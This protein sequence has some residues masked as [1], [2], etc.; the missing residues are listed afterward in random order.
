VA[1]LFSLPT[2]AEWEYACR[3]GTSEIKPQGPQSNTL[4]IIRGGSWYFAADYARSYTRR[5]HLPQLWGFSIGFRIVREK[6]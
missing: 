1:A 6:M 3:A 2:E 5:T 4:K